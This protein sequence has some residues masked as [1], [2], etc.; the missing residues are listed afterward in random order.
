[1]KNTN[2]SLTATTTAV[3]SIVATLAAS[4]V[5]EK[6]SGCAKTSL[7]GKVELGKSTDLTIESTSINDT[8]STRNYRIH[9]PE[10]YEFGTA[11]PLLFSFH[12]RGKDA[13]YQ[14]R[15]SQFSNESFGFGGIAVYPQGIPVCT[16]YSH[17]ARRGKEKKKER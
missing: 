7:P 12:G 10:S 1:M 11:V 13:A 9:V 8:S 3:V 2:L 4:V 6:S 5:A 15:L 14:E 17:E 16:V